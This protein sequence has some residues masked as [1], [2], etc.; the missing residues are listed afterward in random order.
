MSMSR[1]TL[2]RSNPNDRVGGSGCLCKE[3][4][5]AEGC[6]GPY[7]IFHGSTMADPRSPYPVVGVE[8]LNAA[9][10][11]IRR[12]PDEIAESGPAMDFVARMTA[13]TEA[14]VEWDSFT[15]EER[16]AMQAAFPGG[17]VT[18]TS[19]GDY[20]DIPPVDPD[21]A[22]TTAPGTLEGIAL[23]PKVD[24]DPG[25]KPLEEPSAKEGEFVEVVE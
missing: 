12:N 11:Q 22:A 7:V 20:V 19:L 16:F 5:K 14:T 13:P 2:D 3:L 21:H 8:C 1:F 17:G 10:Q 6:D 4:G 23:P 15:D 25:I 9:L 24:Y 18:K